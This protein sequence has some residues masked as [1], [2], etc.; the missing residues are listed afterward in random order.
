MMSA[1]GRN[2][3]DFATAVSGVQLSGGYFMG[4][5]IFWVDILS[6]TEDDLG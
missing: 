6:V 5:P 1:L 2:R 3:T 4:A